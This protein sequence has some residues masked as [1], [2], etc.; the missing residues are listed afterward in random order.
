MSELEV[1]NDL[2][3]G[4]VS[5]LENRNHNHINQSQSDPNHP[6]NPPTDEKF[7]SSQLQNELS[8]DDSIA[9][10]ERELEASNSRVRALEA[11]TKEMDRAFDEA[12]EQRKVAALAELERGNR[13]GLERMERVRNAEEES[14]S[15]ARKRQ[16]VGE[17]VVGAVEAAGM[18][19]VTRSGEGSI[20]VSAGEGQ[21]GGEKTAE[22][23]V[24]AGTANDGSSGQAVAQVEREPMPDIANLPPAPPMTDE[25]K[26]ENE[27]IEEEAS[28]SVMT[29]E[30]L[31][32]HPVAI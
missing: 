19:E 2:Y 7:I 8:K 20:A 11:K 12:L 30:P 31:T 9:R 15:P 21:E 18:G 16:R 6:G 29:G 26:K 13:E 22:V 24:D 4:R 3:K 32:E 17:A 28:R 23:S 10:L 25:E 1:V 5:Q 27:K 14:G